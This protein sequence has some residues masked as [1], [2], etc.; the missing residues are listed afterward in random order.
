MGSE[1]AIGLPLGK[2]PCGKNLCCFGAGPFGKSRCETVIWLTGLF[3]VPDRYGV[4]LATGSG[5]LGSFSVVLA[6]FHA[7][8]AATAPC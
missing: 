3:A 1:Q 5:F 2:T 6:A 4:G 7:K 8:T